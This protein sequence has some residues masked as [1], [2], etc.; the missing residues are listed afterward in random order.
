MDESKRFQIAVYGKTRLNG[1]E[2][3]NSETGM[4][5]WYA[6]ANNSKI[7]INDSISVN[8]EVK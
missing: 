3:E 8:F 2:L 1:K 4:A 6:L 5:K 7:F